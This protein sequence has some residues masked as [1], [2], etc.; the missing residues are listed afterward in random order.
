MGRDVCSTK[1]GARLY[2]AGR[3][4]NAKREGKA[5]NNIGRQKLSWQTDMCEMIPPMNEGESSSHAHLLST[6]RPT[7]KHTNPQRER[8]TQEHSIFFCPADAEKRKKESRRCVRAAFSSPFF[9][10]L[11][12]SPIISQ[13]DTETQK[14]L[15]RRAHICIISVVNG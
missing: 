9:F 15:R 2:I 12:A 7:D 8:H 4:P 13:R 1:R 6:Y 3:Y 11:F 10:F 14:Q 5:N